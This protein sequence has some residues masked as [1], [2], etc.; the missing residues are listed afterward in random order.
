MITASRSKDILL[1]LIMLILSNIKQLVNTLHLVKTPPAIY[2]NR[3]EGKRYSSSEEFQVENSLQDKQII[4]ISPGGWQ[5][6]YMFGVTKY[7]KDHYDLHN[8]IYT[9]ASAGAWN[10]L[11]LS[12]KHNNHDFFRIISKNLIPTKNIADVETNLKNIFLTHFTDRDFALE[13]I[14]LSVTSLQPYMIQ[15]HVYYNFY[16]LED[17]LDCCIASSHIPFITSNRFLN[18]YDGRITFD[19]GLS[20]HPY[21]DIHKPVL[22]ITPQIW[23]KTDF[24]YEKHDNRIIKFAEQGYADTIRYHH[25]LDPIFFRCL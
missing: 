20:M 4:S 17:A 18:R 12:Y 5:G 25:L 15:T 1:I 11:F 14:F 9:G 7:I 13:N 22:H 24:H 16:N 2:Y 21:L 19:G 3:K 23:N 10:S 8:F 6:F